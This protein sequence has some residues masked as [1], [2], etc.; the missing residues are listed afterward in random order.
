MRCSDCLAALIIVVLSAPAQAQ[1]QTFVMDAFGGYVLGDTSTERAN[2]A[3]FRSVFSNGAETTEMVA[4]QQTDR[5]LAFNGPKSL[6]AGQGQ[7]QFVAIGLDGY[8]NMVSDGT[9]VLFR[10]GS[11]DDG[12][13]TTVQGIASHWYDPGARAGL[14]HAGAI[15]GARQSARTEYRVVPDLGRTALAQDRLP[16]LEPDGIGRLTSGQ[17]LDGFGNSVADGTSLQLRLAHGTDG[18]S[19]VPA[20]TILGQAVAR[21]QTLGLP[22]RSDA[23]WSMGPVSSPPFEISVASLNLSGP[24][25]VQAENL[26]EVSGIRLRLGPFLSDAGHHLND[27]TE[28]ALTVS[29]ADV[30]MSQH[31]GWL[32]DGLAEYIL[33]ISSADLPV[34]LDISGRFG[35]AQ[36]NLTSAD[37]TNGA[38]K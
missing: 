12:T 6:V 31:R 1:A 29:V 37:L 15:V 7:G 2:W 36:I 23:T 25:E 4:P 32:S 11:N 14:F 20:K 13:E 21:F 19:L 34:S 5:V 30:V 3:G 9:D 35:D 28:V 33:P 38:G 18:E 24:P 27:G 26:P 16:L 10:L 8:G 17:L 22:E